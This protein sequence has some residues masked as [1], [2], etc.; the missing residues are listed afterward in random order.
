MT[1][2]GLVMALFILAGPAVLAAAPPAP[3][4]AVV[5]PRIVTDKSIDCSTVDRILAGLIRKDMTDEQK[6]LACFHW[7]RRLIYHGD[8]PVQYAYNFHNMINVYGHGSC[9][10]E[11]TPMWV[12]LSRLGYKCRTGSIG[13]HHIIEVEYGGKWHL[14]DPH[15]NFYV[16]DRSTPPAIASIE[17]IKQDTTLVSDAVKNGRACPGFLL[18]GDSP[19][20]FATREGWQIFGDFPE[21]KKYTP[22]IEEPFGRITLR[23]GETYVRTWMPGPYWF[24]ANSPKKG[25]GPR[26]GC[27]GRDLKDTVNG[28]LYEPHGSQG[29]YRHWGAGYLLYRPDL[30]SDHYADAVV[31]QKDLTTGKTADGAG[32]VADKAGEVTFGV[33]CPYVI[34]AGELKFKRL[35]QGSFAAAV[36]VDRGATWKPVELKDDQGAAAALFVE[37]V[38]GSFAGYWLKLS[39]PAGAGIGDLEL[40]SHFQ[41][42]PY[43]LPYLVPGRNAVTLGAETL[44]SP[45]RVEWQYAEG[46]AWTE[47]KSAAETFTKPGEFVIEVRGDKYPRNVSLTLSVAP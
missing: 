4:A 29:K 40:K 42:N 3:G 43:S 47:I 20:T 38:N 8:G 44:G 11:T 6:V 12:L 30:G 5:N 45:L 34:T 31:E 26:H 46:P 15:M 25:E 36:S 1:A 10:R 9:L 28:P 35:G 19:S 7:I 23:R 27:G 32:L 18:C 13:G 37:P 33:N 21:S 17:Q 39:V 22:V 16:Y 41:L 2:A 14:F 24:I